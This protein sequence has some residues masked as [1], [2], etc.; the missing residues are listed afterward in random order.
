MT[1]IA[2]KTE[3]LLK[4]CITDRQREVLQAVVNTNGVR[5][6]SRELGVTPRTVRDTIQRVES[7]AAKRGYAPE[8]DMTKVCPDGYVVKGTSTLYDGD[9]TA[10]NQWVKTEID[11]KQQ[12][13]L[14]EQFSDSLCK[15]IKAAKPVAQS[16]GKLDS[17]RLVVYPIG[18]AHVGLYCWQ[19]D[20]EEDWDMQIASKIY[21]AAFREIIADSPATEHA[22]VINL[23]DWFHTDNAENQ[24]K[25]SGHALDVDSRYHRVV[26]IGTEIMR[27]VV[28]AV[29]KK[30]KTVTLINEVGNHDDLSA[31]HLSRELAAFYRNEPRVTVDLSPDSFHWYEFGNNFFGVH[32]GHKCR[33]ERLY[34]VMTEDKREETGRCKHRYWFVGHIH[35]ESKIS[36]GNMT[37]ESFA[38]L[39]PRD[40]YAHSSGYRAKRQIQSIIYDRQHGECGRRTLH[41]DAIKLEE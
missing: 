30:H 8:A 38:T 39:I 37:F 4:F 22:L 9:G 33:K 6:A 17:D 34:Q 32:H 11:S 15:S 20:A 14:L 24:T 40:Q 18:D 10:L 23:G 13:M 1:D 28:E 3:P 35:H 26:D 5:P 41:V 19:E 12:K 31:Y 36:V 29:L 27:R 2:K 25:R 16:K 21:N 7:L